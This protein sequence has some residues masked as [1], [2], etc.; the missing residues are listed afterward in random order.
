ML[1]E[2]DV[3]GEFSVSFDEFFGAVEGV[4]DPEVGQVLSVWVGV[5]CAFLG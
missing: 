4:D 1:D 5:V 3:D 2:C